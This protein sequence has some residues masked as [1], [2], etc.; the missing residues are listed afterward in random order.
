VHDGSANTMALHTSAGCTITGAGGTGSLVTSNCD[1]NAVGQA[2]NQ[3]C[4]INDLRATS[5]GAGFND[6]GGGVYA[7]E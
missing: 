5:Y 2:A 3:G 1:V 6:I 4:V 7:T